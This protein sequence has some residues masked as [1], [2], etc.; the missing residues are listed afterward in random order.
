V[1][2]AFDSA[3][4]RTGQVKTSVHRRHGVQ[5]K[6]VSAQANGQVRPHCGAR[7]EPT[8]TTT[9]LEGRTSSGVD[10]PSQ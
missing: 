8:G 4:R 10:L 1:A 6:I 3:G 9:D 5:F 7:R 2:A